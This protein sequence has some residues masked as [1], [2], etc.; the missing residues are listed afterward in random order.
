M[1]IL[2]F[3]DHLVAALSYDL[4]DCVRRAQTLDLALSRQTVRCNQ[5]LA[6]ISILR[7]YPYPFRLNHSLG[8]A[9][10]GMVKSQT[11]CH[12]GDPGFIFN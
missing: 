1:A 9:L 2:L 11:T 10:Y 3:S 7:A 6:S 12:V 5:D 8:L 4:A